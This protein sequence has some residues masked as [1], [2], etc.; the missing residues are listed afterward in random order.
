MNKKI[1]ITT[2]QN[3]Y[4]GKTLFDN[5]ASSL[6]IDETFSL[7]DEEGTMETTLFGNATISNGVYRLR[8]KESNDSG[9]ENVTTTIKFKLDA[10]N[11]VTLIRTGD[12]SSVMYF[13]QG[14]RDLSVYNSGVFPF[15]VCIFTAS[16]DNRLIDDGFFEVC[17]IV[18]IRGAQAQKTILRLEATSI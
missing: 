3:D 8:Y 6:L 11:E 12:V 5:I 2:I 1:K 10:P 9:M 15:E 17:Y 4:K 18:E 13:E 16:V 14:K 7:M